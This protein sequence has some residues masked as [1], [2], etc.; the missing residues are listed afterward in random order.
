MTKEAKEMMAVRLDP[1]DRRALRAIA[2]RLGVSDSDLLRYAVKVVLDDFASLVDHSKE[3]AQLLEAFLQHAD[4][5]SRWL[6][7]DR[8]KLDAILHTDLENER[9]RVDS[10]DIELLLRGRTSKGFHAWLLDF[11]TSHKQPP[12]FLLNRAAYLTDKYVE[13][14][15]DA[16]TAEELEEKMRREKP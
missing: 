16:E 5:K 7:L 9:L 8:S 12:A 14:L 1:S 15:R 10:E 3:G 11:F 4:E 2:A 6:G 13:P